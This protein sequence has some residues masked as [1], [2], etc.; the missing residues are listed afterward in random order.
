MAHNYGI[1]EV[2]RLYLPT[3]IVSASPIPTRTQQE[4][5]PDSLPEPPI[6]APLVLLCIGYF[7]IHKILLLSSTLSNI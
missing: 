4:T 7:I 2:F 5:V 3:S 6:E 1:D